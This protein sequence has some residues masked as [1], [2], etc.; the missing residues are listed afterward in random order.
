[1]VISGLCAKLFNAA[2]C[3]VTPM[4][5]VIPEFCQFKGDGPVEHLFHVMAFARG[6]CLKHASS[7]V[8]CLSCSLS[9]SRVWN[10]KVICNID[11]KIN[12]WVYKLNM[13]E[14]IAQYYYLSQPNI[15]KYVW[16]L[17]WWKSGYLYT[18]DINYSWANLK[19]VINSFIVSLPLGL[20]AATY[21]HNHLV[22]FLITLR[23][24]SSYS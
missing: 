4:Y 15:G 6:F 9:C 17:C 10:S 5:S 8:S 12:C 22:I 16:N 20:T 21:K 7:T 23:R 1:M 14:N 18:V 3:C 19:F 13:H 24:H 11:Y 2:V